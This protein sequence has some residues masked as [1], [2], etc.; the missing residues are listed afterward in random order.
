MLKCLSYSLKT[1]VVFKQ[2]NFVRVHI[3]NRSFRDI[4]FRTIVP[5]DM[6]V[7]YKAQQLPLKI[8][9]HIIWKYSIS[10]CDWQIRFGTEVVRVERCSKHSISG[11]WRVRTRERSSGAECEQ[12]FDAVLVASGHNHLPYVPHINGVCTCCYDDKVQYTWERN[13][14]VTVYWKHFGERSA[15]RIFT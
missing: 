6:T 2:Y 13:Y 7:S 9:T 12:T 15:M 14:T 8:A 5:F 10:S 4:T 3:L 1:F 11:Q